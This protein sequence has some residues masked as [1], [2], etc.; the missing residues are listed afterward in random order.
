MKNALYA[1]VLIALLL[2][3]CSTR[4]RVKKTIRGTKTLTYSINTSGTF[5]QSAY[6]R[7]TTLIDA[8]TGNSYDNVQIEE[9]TLSGVN[10]NMVTNSVSKASSVTIESAYIRCVRSG[11]L[12]PEKSFSLGSTTNLEVASFLLLGGVSEINTEVTN[13][14]KGLNTDDLRVSVIGAAVPRGQ[15]AS[16]TLVVTLSYTVKFS[17]CMDFNGFAPLGCPE[18]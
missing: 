10:F 5:N 6:V 11:V 18:C 3:G 15:L 2:V 14:L 17:H 7:A 1:L 8:L 12:M 16:L 13:L 4:Y 9:F